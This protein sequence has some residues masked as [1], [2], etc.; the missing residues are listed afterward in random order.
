MK[1]FFQALS[2]PFTFSD[3]KITSVFILYYKKKLHMSQNFYSYRN[4]VI[5]AA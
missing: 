3:V 1:V 2:S 5:A 4:Y